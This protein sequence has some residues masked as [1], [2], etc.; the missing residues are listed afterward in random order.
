MGH[1]AWG[2]GR[3]ET[4]FFGKGFWLPGKTGFLAPFLAYHQPER[5]RDDKKRQN[6]SPKR[7]ANQPKIR[8]KI[9]APIRNAAKVW[10]SH[11]KPA[12]IAIAMP[13]MA[14]QP[15]RTLNSKRS[16]RLGGG[17][18]SVIFGNGELGLMALG[19]WHW[20]LGQINDA[21]KQALMKSAKHIQKNQNLPYNRRP[22]CS[23]KFLILAGRP[24]YNSH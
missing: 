4:R 10:A 21:S 3:L 17:G 5:I 14:P 16:G 8:A 12:D 23:F 22:A 1:G 13:M 15:K 18:V 2:I 19:L 9:S 11:S 6:L 20:A 24:S 7:A